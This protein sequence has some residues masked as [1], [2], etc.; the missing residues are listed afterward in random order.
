MRKDIYNLGFLHLS[1]LSRIVSFSYS[2]Y[3]HCKYRFL[4]LCSL[5]ATLDAYLQRLRT[6]EEPQVLPGGGIASCPAPGRILTYLRGTI[7]STGR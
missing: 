5:V 2:Q 3:H 4:F 7:P 1:K 6:R